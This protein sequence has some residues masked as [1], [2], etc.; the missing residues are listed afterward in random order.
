MAGH[1]RAEEHHN[2]WLGNMRADVAGDRAVLEADAMVL[3]REFI[4]AHLF[5]YC[6]YLGFYDLLTKRD[7]AWQISRATSIYE[8]DQLDLVIPS[9]APASFFAG[10]DLTGGDAGF[11]YMRFRQMKKGRA[12]PSGI[13]IAGS[14]AE[15]TLREEGMAWLAGE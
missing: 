14:E 4:D 6:C 10:I 8:K 5:D 12:V 7:G 15:Q 1:R 9:T 13:V 2:H 11:A 3:I